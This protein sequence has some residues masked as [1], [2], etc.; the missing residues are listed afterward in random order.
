M[1]KII[2]VLLPESPGKVAMPQ[3]PILFQDR[4]PADCRAADTSVPHLLSPAN[5]ND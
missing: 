4:F 5:Q 1:R 3:T 2:T